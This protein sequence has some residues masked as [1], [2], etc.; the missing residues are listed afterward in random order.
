MP[1][2]HTQLSAQGQTPDGK[3]ITIP[4]AIALMQ[5]GPIVQVIIGV[6]Q[7]IAKQLFSQGY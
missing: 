3:A 7:N 4:P 2:L 5:R 6:E 1:I